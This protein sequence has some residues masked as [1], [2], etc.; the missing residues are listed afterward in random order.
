MGRPEAGAGIT[1][2]KR[3]CADLPWWS[4]MA[5]LCAFFA[6]AVEQGGCHPVGR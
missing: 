2:A 4:L 3:A 5:R 6:C 1:T